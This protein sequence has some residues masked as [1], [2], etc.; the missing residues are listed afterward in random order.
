VGCIKGASFQDML[1][2][3]KFKCGDSKGARCRT[4]V[5]VFSLPVLL[6]E[7]LKL[8]TLV[9]QSP[10]ALATFQKA[11]CFWATFLFK[12]IPQFHKR[13]LLQSLFA[14]LGALKSWLQAQEQVRNCML[15][16]LFFKAG[17]TKG[18]SRPALFSMPRLDSSSCDSL[19]FLCR[20][21]LFPCSH[22]VRT[23]E[24]MLSRFSVMG[25]RCRSAGSWTR[26]LRQGPA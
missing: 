18:P 2:I 25:G 8:E 22:L 24:R 11:S 3:S 14:R 17:A 21:S 16:L 19:L 23:L 13:Q 5:L 12:Q 9:F 15:T 20:S 1:Q 6:H 10:P 7:W 26:V 4:E